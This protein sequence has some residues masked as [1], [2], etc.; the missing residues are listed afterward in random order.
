VNR[1][2][3]SLNVLDVLEELAG[4]SFRSVNLPLSEGQYAEDKGRES[5]ALSQSGDLSS[6]VDEHSRQRSV[7]SS[8]EA[9]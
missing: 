9:K 8:G 4:V 2:R 3:S 5:G 7:T 1:V 6:R